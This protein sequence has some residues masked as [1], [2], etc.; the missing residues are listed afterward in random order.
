LGEAYAA[1]GFT[2]L[3]PAHT[4]V[5]QWFLPDGEHLV[6]LAARAQIVRRTAKGEMVNR[7]ARETVEKVREEWTQ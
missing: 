4:P 2:D 7:I 6:E 1:A 5:F 3:R